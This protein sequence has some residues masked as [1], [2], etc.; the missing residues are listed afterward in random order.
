MKQLSGFFYMQTDWRNA[1]GN[2]LC[3]TFLWC[4]QDSWWWR[5]VMVLFSRL[6]Y[7][8]NNNNNIKKD[9]LSVHR[10]S[11]PM[12]TWEN[13]FCCVPSHD[14][15]EKNNR[16]S[17]CSNHLR[18]EYFISSPWKSSL[19]ESSRNKAC[20]QRFHKE[21]SVSQ[22]IKEQIRNKNTGKQDKRKQESCTSAEE[23]SHDICIPGAQSRGGITSVFGAW[24]VK[25][26]ACWLQPRQTAFVK[27]SAGC[28]EMP[29]MAF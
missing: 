22:I 6:I 26:I 10:Y 5:A 20:L 11:F 9:S 8:N 13:F 23:W 14:G 3:A 18:S 2:S 24:R 27:Y 16:F 1:G 15:K 12:K 29:R 7:N 25:H 4:T 28:L 19:L 21:V 17:V